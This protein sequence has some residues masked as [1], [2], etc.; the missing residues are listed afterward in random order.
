MRIALQKLIADLFSFGIV[1]PP[2]RAALPVSARVP[3]HHAFERAFP[4]RPRWLADSARP[5][6]KSRPARPGCPYLWGPLGGSA[7][8]LRGAVH[9]PAAELPARKPALPMP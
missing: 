5:W 6:N 2:R 4:E 8:V 3:D 9:N 1:A 7:P